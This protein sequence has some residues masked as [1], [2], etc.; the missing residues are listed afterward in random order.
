MA[1]ERL[2]ALQALGVEMAFSNVPMNDDNLTKL[3]PHQAS[4]HQLPA[5]SGPPLLEPAFPVSCMPPA[6]PCWQKPGDI[7]DVDTLRSWGI[8]GYASQEAS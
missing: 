3:R 4:L 8:D 7:D 5:D 1:E 6:I 2:G